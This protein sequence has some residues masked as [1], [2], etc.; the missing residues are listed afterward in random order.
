M[1]AVILTTLGTS[2]HG[3]PISIDLDFSS[4][5]TTFNGVSQATGAMQVSIVTD[6]TTL[7]SG[8]GFGSF[9]NFYA[10]DVFFTAAALGLNKTKLS[11]PAY[12]YFAADIVGFTTAIGTFSTILSVKGGSP[13]SFGTAFDISTIVSPQGPVALTGTEMRTGTVITLDNGDVFD[14]AGNI[15]LV[16]TQTNSA[17]VADVVIS[18]PGLAMI[19]GISVLG[20][21]LVRRNRTAS[22]S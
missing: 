6:T 19:F 22:H 4:F 21:A 14:I 13:L 7:N 12:L 17:T 18:E 11:G 9:S 16:G 1:C 5:T 3:S 10:A 20:L 8:S 15:N 2:A